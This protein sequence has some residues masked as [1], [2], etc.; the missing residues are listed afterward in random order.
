M[1]TWI[2]ISIAISACSVAAFELIREVP[3]EDEMLV[4]GHYFWKGGLGQ[5][6]DSLPPN[7]RWQQM[8]D[9]D[10]D[11]LMEEFTRAGDQLLVP[12][13]PRSFN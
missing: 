13:S 9:S 12:D 6:A 2:L 8:N 3:G 4:G 1:L 11:D 5:G 10:L 7:Q